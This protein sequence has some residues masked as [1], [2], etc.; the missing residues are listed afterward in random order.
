MINI[1]TKTTGEFVF[2][3]DDYEQ[4]VY[5]DYNDIPKDFIFR[6]VIKFMPDI[7]PPP[8]T[9]EQHLEI[10]EWNERF[11][12]LMDKEKEMCYNNGYET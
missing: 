3:D 4:V 10:K 7:P 11:R 1:L 5:N 9:P 8:H 2:L 12:K 6:H